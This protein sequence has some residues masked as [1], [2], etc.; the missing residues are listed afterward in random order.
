[1]FHPWVCLIVPISL[2]LLSLIGYAIKQAFPCLYL[3]ASNLVVYN[4]MVWN[5][6]ASL[7]S[8]DMQMHNDKPKKGGLGIS[9]LIEDRVIETLLKER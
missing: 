9:S 3:A 2:S 4:L 8:I 7:S 5:L 1:M 6:I